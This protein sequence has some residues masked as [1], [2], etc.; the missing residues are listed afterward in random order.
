VAVDSQGWKELSEIHRHAV[1]EVE[2][3]RDEC[4]DRL[5]QGAEEPLRAISWLMLLEL[6][7]L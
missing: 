7:D 2:R 5:D 3:V 1:E 6:P 4:A